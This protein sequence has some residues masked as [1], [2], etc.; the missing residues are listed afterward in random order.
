MALCFPSTPQKLL[1]T[2]GLFLGGSSLF[3]V[4]LY[5]SY[6]HVAPQQARIQARNDYVRDRLK[7]K[8]GYDMYN[9]QPKKD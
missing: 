1:M 2:V 8:Y 4:G 5:L 9:T 7:K 6:V 3:G